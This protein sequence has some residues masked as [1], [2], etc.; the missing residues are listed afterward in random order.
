M[1][2]QS[3]VLGNVAISPRQ[4]TQADEQQY[5]QAVKALEENRFDFSGPGAQHNH[6]LLVQYFE[7]NRQVPVTVANVYRAVEERRADF[8]PLTPAE[9]AWY[10]AAKENPEL[11][12]QLA[13][14]LATHG[15]PGRLANSGDPLFE[16]LLLL[17]KELQSRHES[18]S[19]YTLRGAEDRIAHRPRKQLHRVAQPRRTTPMS[20]AARKDDGKPFLGSDMVKTPDGG[21]RNKTPAEQAAERRAAEEAQSNPEQ[22]RLSVEDKEWKSM[23]QEL[24]R[25]GTHGQQA[26]IKQTYDKAVQSG[27][28]WRRVYEAC[29]RVVSLYKRGAAVSGSLR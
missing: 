20:E 4:Y 10:M 11:A 24:L 15:Q 18:V 1:E 7:T 5:A 17:F 21:W 8:K 23:S 2:I 12:N 14:H 3:A 27:A 26:Q 16:N 29:N 19:A 6:E 22:E 9:S 25:Y 13:L 28:D